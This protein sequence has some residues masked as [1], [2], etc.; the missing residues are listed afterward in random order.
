[1]NM[2]LVFATKCRDSYALQGPSNPGSQKLRNLMGWSKMFLKKVSKRQDFF[3][4]EKTDLSH[5]TDSFA[6][7]FID[8]II[9]ETHYFRNH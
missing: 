6:M 5:L 9:K 4:Q 3:P 7:S 1:M 8:V 2:G